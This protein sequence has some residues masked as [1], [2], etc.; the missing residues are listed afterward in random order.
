MCGPF[1]FQ[2]AAL[3]LL[4]IVGQPLLAMPPAPSEQ[5]LE[6]PML[7]NQTFDPA[8][9]TPEDILG[10]TPGA[11]ALSS[12]EIERCL[13]AWVDAP[14][15][16]LLEY[17]RT[18]Q[19]RSLY[20]M[21][22]T[23]PSNHAR[24]DQI[25]A[26]AR[27]LADPRGLSEADGTALIER[28]PAV[29][30]LGY[31]IHGDESSGANA[32]IQLLY[33]VLAAQDPV[34]EAWLE[35][36]VLIIDPLMNPDGRSRFIAQVQQYRGRF[37]E[38]DNQSRVHRAD[39]PSG[40]G[41]HYR[42]DLN[43][44]WLLASQPETKARL[45]L[46]RDWTP[47]LV[48]DGHEMGSDQTFLFPPA[49]EPL[50]PYFPEHVLAG[51]RH[52]SA[53]QAAAFDAEGRPYYTQEWLDDWFPGYTTSFAGLHGA[54]PLL[55]EQ[56]SV[57][58]GGVRRPE[59]RVVTYADAVAQQRLATV[60]AVAAL[61][62]DRTAFKQA[63]LEHRRRAVSPQGP[64]AEQA[65]V[66]LPSANDGRVQA[67]LAVL[68]QHEIEYFRLSTATSAS[69]AI[70]QLGQTHAALELPPG[71]LVIPNRQPLAHWVAAMFEFDPPLS[72]SALA[73][74]RHAILSEGD[75]TIYDVTAWNLTMLF[76][77]PSYTLRDGASA[78]R[79]QGQPDSH[80]DTTS[81]PI[82]PMQPASP[83]GPPT[84]GLVLDG[85][86]DRAVQA[87]AHLLTAGVE[88]RF[89]DRP[90]RLDGQAFARGSLVALAIDNADGPADWAERVQRSASALG[91]AVHRIE[92]ALGPGR[93][94]E[95]GGRHAI[96]LEPPRL[97]L[98]DGDAVDDPSFGALWHLFDHRLGLPHSRLERDDLRR[99]DLRRYN[100]LVLSDGRR[101]R[102]GDHRE[103]LEAWVRAGGTLIA[104]GRAAGDLAVDQGLSSVRRL[105]D[106]LEGL[107]AYSDQ[108]LREWQ[109]DVV[110][111]SPGAAVPASLAEILSAM[112]RGHGVAEAVY[113]W[114]GLEALPALEERTR[115]DEWNARFMPQGV[116]LAARVDD[117]HWLTVGTEEPLPLLVDQS[118][119]VLM[120][121]AGVDAVAR[122]GYPLP[123]ADAPLRR[124]GFAPV[125]AGRGLTLR[126]SGLLWPEAAQRLAQAAV[127]TREAL[128]HGQIILFAHVP[129]LRSG[130][131]AATRMLTNAVVY[132]PGVGAGAAVV[133]PRP[134][135]VSV[136]TDGQGG[137][138]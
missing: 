41:N 64:F 78:L 35:S 21:V 95:L 107:E 5:P 110:A 93:A 20:A 96:R 89:V 105:P 100:V 1:R 83:A 15:A 74:E 11:R 33:E 71:S 98:V 129:A 53:A 36:M 3:A 28:M 65:F 31:S 34:T 26:D 75:S 14:R 42:F 130:T 47:V 25:Q 136:G 126:M 128:G 23:S 52:V 13:Q 127:V 120:V 131:P 113:P 102:F 17:G 81:A 12:A 69:G 45:A 72:S 92:S 119:P 58:D 29:A 18:H 50:N 97:A 84:V 63:F 8:I 123:V 91:L 101:G 70:D 57:A 80:T 114:D 16:R 61:Y 111:V 10:I 32:A 54:V 22:V 87:A 115:R 59:G 9:A 132:G 116:I 90:L 19:G 73:A 94:P 44:D 7:A 86:D 27:R 38:V 30:W 77:L 106:G 68:D 103:R 43:R 104:T 67:L 55:L 56:G 46:L 60:A 37:A 135:P 2:C 109:A 133:D 118:L 66:I 125:P 108:V 79:T 134:T 62:R 51:I 117:Q 88:L 138:Y 40:R 99:V 49:R 124:Q 82:R 122:L 112:S 137:A 48:V 85:A 24:L 39:R 76:G 6:L 4:W 121:P